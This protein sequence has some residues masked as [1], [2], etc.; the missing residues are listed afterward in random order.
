MYFV[1]NWISGWKR[2]KCF[3]TQIPH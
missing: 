2:Y 1:F 3:T